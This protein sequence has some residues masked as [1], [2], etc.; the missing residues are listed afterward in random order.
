ME[1]FSK[2]THRSRYIRE[3]NDILSRRTTLLA[4]YFPRVTLLQINHELCGI[5]I[6]RTHL[7]HEILTRRTNIVALTFIYSSSLRTA[8]SLPRRITQIA[9][10][11]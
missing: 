7:G 3:I 9:D 2:S 5:D 8:D 1:G 4:I 10:I 11:S 6:S